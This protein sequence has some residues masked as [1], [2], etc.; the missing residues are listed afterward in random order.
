MHNV[1]ILHVYEVKSFILLTTP[2]WANLASDTKRRC[3]Q[4]QKAP[5]RPR[6]RDPTLLNRPLADRGKEDRWWKLNNK[7]RRRNR[8]RG[9]RRSRWWIRKE[10]DGRWETS[11]YRTRGGRLHPR[12]RN[13]KSKKI[14]QQAQ[15]KSVQTTGRKSH[16]LFWKEKGRE[17]E[18]VLESSHAFTCRL[19]DVEFNYPGMAR[20]MKEA[21]STQIAIRE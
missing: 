1:Y 9:R 6:G 5:G 12:E 8:S 15:E 3:V 16:T 18:K 14:I 2:D 20:K 4:G 19:P 10:S 11:E 17:R 7:R 21:I 13:L